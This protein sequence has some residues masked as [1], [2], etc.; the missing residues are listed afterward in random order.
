[1][2]GAAHPRPL[3]VTRHQP[4]I[5]T[6]RSGPTALPPTRFRRSLRE[7]ENLYERRLEAQGQQFDALKEE[8]DRMMVCV[9]FQPAIFTHPPPSRG[10]PTPHSIEG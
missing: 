5:L 6:A 7:L 3:P 10:P 4:R 2:G 9:R 1:M 8:Y